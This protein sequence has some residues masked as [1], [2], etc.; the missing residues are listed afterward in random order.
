MI[1]DNHTYTKEQIINEIMNSAW[2]IADLCRALD[3]CYKS[4]KLSDSAM[5]EA[6]KAKH[7]QISHLIEK[8]EKS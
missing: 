1:E 6:L 4:N 5:F 3:R 2:C 8:Y 7:A